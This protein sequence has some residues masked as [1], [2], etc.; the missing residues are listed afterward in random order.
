MTGSDVE[1][2]L[3]DVLTEP[4]PSAL[5]AWAATGK[6][7]LKRLRAELDGTRH[8]ALPSSCDPRDTVEHLGAAIAALA[9][10]EPDEFLATFSAPAWRTAPGVVTGLGVIDRPAAT[11]RLLEAIAGPDPRVRTD[12]AIGLGNREGPEVTA[13]L[14]AALDDEA[15]FVRFHALRSLA[16]VGDASALDALHS[17]ARRD[18]A[19]SWELELAGA[20]VQII[21]ARAALVDP[22][23]RCRLALSLGDL[24][25]ARRA[26]PNPDDWPDDRPCED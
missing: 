12:A 19:E 4:T 13:S 3:V 9:E 5:S 2:L 15:Q 18:D 1:A 21:E 25:G 16:K 24:P 14:V 7:G 11:R 6:A 8:A 22:T 26:I 23:E 17:L 10:A 20:A